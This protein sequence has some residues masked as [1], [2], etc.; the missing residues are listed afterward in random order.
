MFA[1][2]IIVLQLVLVQREAMALREAVRVAHESADPVSA[3]DNVLY[4]L[5]VPSLIKDFVLP[6]LHKDPTLRCKPL[7][8]AT[9]KLT[10]A[11]RTSCA[12]A[13]RRPAGWALL[14]AAHPR[15]LPGA[16]QACGPLRIWKRERRSRAS[17]WEQ[18][19]DVHFDIQ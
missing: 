2:G 13:T 7:T 3:L 11:G 10:Q 17:T 15:V 9:L 12:I 8:C 4:R 18:T 5:R 16:V 1:F 14:D 19:L 6:C